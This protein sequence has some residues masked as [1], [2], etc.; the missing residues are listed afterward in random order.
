MRLVEDDSSLLL[1]LVGFLSTVHITFVNSIVSP[2]VCVMNILMHI[3]VCMSVVVV[4]NGTAFLHLYV[5]EELHEY[6]NIQNSGK[7]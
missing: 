5:S 7:K 2:H 4:C 3:F 1:E 6:Y